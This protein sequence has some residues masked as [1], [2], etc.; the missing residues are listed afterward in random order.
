M[1]VLTT[2]MIVEVSSVVELLQSN[3]FD[4][5]RFS[6]DPSF[7]RARHIIIDRRLHLSATDGLRE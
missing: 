5:S 6:L 4:I 2:Y 3:R 7:F 1:T